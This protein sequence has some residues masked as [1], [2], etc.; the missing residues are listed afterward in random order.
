[1][2]TTQDN[3]SAAPYAMQRLLEAAPV[4]LAVALG[5]IIGGWLT[6]PGVMQVAV[7]MLIADWVTGFAK[8]YVVHQHLKSAP[9]VRGAVKSLVYAG[10]LGCGWLMTH[11]GPIPELAGQA[12]ALYVITTEAISNLE[13][14]QAIADRFGVEAPALRGALRILRIKAAELAPDTEKEEAHAPNP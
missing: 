2:A 8:G 4:K 6:T 7:W 3:I 12:I 5:V 11:G 1:M 9:M 10:L 14:L 13:N